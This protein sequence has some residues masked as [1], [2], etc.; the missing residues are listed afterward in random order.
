MATRPLAAVKA[1]SLDNGAAIMTINKGPHAREQ[2]D[3]G[4]ILERESHLIEIIF[5][6][7]SAQIIRACNVSAPDA[8]KSADHDANHRDREQE[9]PPTE[10]P[11]RLADPNLQNGRERGRVTLPFSSICRCI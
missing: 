5:Q 3:D 9:R 8:V 1:K 4:L 6:E 7:E 11:H 2:R 10:M